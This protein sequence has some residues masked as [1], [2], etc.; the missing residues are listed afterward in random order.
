MIAFKVY[1]Q[2]FDGLGSTVEDYVLIPHYVG[3][4]Y[5]DDSGFYA[6]K[7][8]RAAKEYAKNVK[9]AIICR[10][11]TNNNRMSLYYDR[12]GMVVVRCK[13]LT[14]LK[15]LLGNEISKRL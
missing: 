14:V 10:I 4:T 2:Q 6:W 11:K 1:R 3:G 7:T 5:Y 9:G 8:L 13:K 15:I 12:K